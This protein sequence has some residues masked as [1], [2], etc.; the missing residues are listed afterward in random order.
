MEIPDPADS[1]NASSTKPP[2]EIG[3]IVVG[4]TSAADL[5]AIHTAR[6]RSKEILGGLFPQFAWRVAL[7]RRHE[8]NLESSPEAAALLEYGAQE[9]DAMAF[10]FAFV[11]TEADL[12]AH[13][14]P[15]ALGMPAMAMNVAVLSTARIDPAEIGDR[16]EHRV[17]LMSRRLLALVMHLFG[18]LNDLPHNSKSSNFMYDVKTVADLD[19]MNT[20]TDGQIEQLR[21][22]L[23]EEA[24]L[25]LEELDVGRPEATAFYVRAGWHSG[26]DIARTVLRTRPWLFP[27]RLSK[28]TTAALSALLVL[29]TTAEAWDLGMSQSTA[30]VAGFSLTALVA[31]VT[32]IL[33]RQR[34]VIRRQER[35]LSEQRV[36]SNLSA[37]L[38]V[39][40]GMLI[41]YALL[42]AGTFFVSQTVFSRE[43]V[44]GWAASLD[45]DIALGHYLLLAGFV[46]SLG[47]A[48][49]ALGASFE[50]H[51]YFRHIIY[52]D[53]E[54]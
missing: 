36:I 43:L 37:V 53:E 21:Q 7:V 28:L 38:S 48:I 33:K 47:L 14:K 4:P 46:A 8:V 29:L 19:D 16:D 32:F 6:A 34:L 30:A 35:R 54:T 22:E 44:T 52:V 39:T 1:T 51:D 42:F 15:F 9:R 5:E 12:K 3:W 13:Y 50:A 26:A 31:T 41:T 40:A 49:G 10:D 11:V 24:D 20:F 27:F 23:Q 45:G 2:L 25:R 18:H 17:E